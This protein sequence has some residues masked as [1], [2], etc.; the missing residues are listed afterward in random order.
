MPY[1]TTEKVKEYLERTKEHR[2]E[3]YK[4]YT[5]RKRK[6]LNKIKL[7]WKKNNM[8]K[9]KIYGERY[10]NKNR[11]KIRERLKLYALKNPEKI[12]LH[13]LKCSLKKRYKLTLDQYNEMYSKQKSKCGIC[14]IHE[15]K[16]TKKLN[17]DHNHRTGKARE[18]LCQKCN[19]ALSYFE[20]FDSKPFL[21][22]LNKHREKLN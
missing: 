1:N 16:I 19:V 7:E 22:Y 6:H 2:A 17:I 3:V 8:N 11:E 5:K 14:G 13:R 18:L 9:T 20:N 15:S 21:E 12:K 10:R 4:K